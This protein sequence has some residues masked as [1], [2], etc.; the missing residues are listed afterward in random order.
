[1]QARKMKWR[2]ETQSSTR[3]KETISKLN[4]VGVLFQH[5]VGHAS[6]VSKT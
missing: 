5:F 3:G 4:F 1:M 2:K 6:C